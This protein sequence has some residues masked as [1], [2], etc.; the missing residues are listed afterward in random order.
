MAA[1]ISAVVVFCASEAYGWGSSPVA[2]LSV[3]PY[4]CVGSSVTFNACLSQDPDVCPCTGCPLVT[5]GNCG[6]TQLRNGIRTYCWNF[7]DGS[8]VYC[9]DPGDAIAYHAYTSA[10]PYT[11]TLTVWDHD[12]CAGRGPDKS[13]TCTRLVSAVRVDKIHV[14]PLPVADWFDVT[15]TTI[16]V[17]KGAIYRFKALPYPPDAGWPSGTPVWSGIVSGSGETIDVTFNNVG[18]E[19]LVVGC[20]PTP[21]RTVTINEVVLEPDEVSFLD[22]Y[23]GDEHDIYGV[24]DPVWKRV[25]NPDN[26]ACYTKYKFIKVGG[27]FWA[28]ENLTYSTKIYVDLQDQST[29]WTFLSNEIT[30]KNWPS[31]RSDHRSTERLADQI[32]AQEYTFKWR[33]KVPPPGANTWIDMAN[34]S[35]PHKVYTVF[36]AP[37]APEAPPKKY[38]LDYACTWADSA[39]TKAG[40]CSDILSNGF[41]SHYTWDYNCH[42]LSSDFVRLVAS[43][44]VN[45][46]QHNWSS[47]GATAVDYMYY[48]RTRTFDPVGSAHGSSVYQWAW[49][50]WGEAEGGQYD[51]S[52]GASLG[53]SW[54]G[55]EDDFFTHYQ[56]VTQLVPLQLQWVANQSGQSS[57]CEA[58]AHRI[59]SNPSP[60]T[61][62]GP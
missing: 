6:V 53:G 57:G 32:A 60:E 48:R 52:A 58:P 44:G 35:G 25:S 16:V 61:W 55:Y 23:A 9:E 8:P 43:L 62:M 30:V 36:E 59:Y 14:M 38:I 39:T 26:P 5:C 21:E 15:G 46:S 17:L 40:A 37:K 28:S 12:L 29:G 50:Q 2:D 51:P 42:R 20:R 10:G 54:G 34:T 3:D 7:G 24:S 27:K 11:V 45:A 47:K 4:V 1:Y 18:T 41:A 19:F 49:H 33:Y 56:K 31:A 22:F 13:G